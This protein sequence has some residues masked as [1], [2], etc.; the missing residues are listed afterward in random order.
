MATGGVWAFMPILLRIAARCFSLAV[1]RLAGAL[2]AALAG[3]AALR[4]TVLGGA[5]AKARTGGA[6]NERGAAMTCVS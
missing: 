3:A 2:V 4:A 6:G 1:R 5:G